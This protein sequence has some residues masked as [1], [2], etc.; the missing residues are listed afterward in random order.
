MKICLLGEFTGD[1]DEGM[2]KTSF[3]LAEELSK[4]HQ[5]ITL[6][7]RDVYSRN[8]WKKIKC[9]RPDIIHY[10]HGPSIKSFVLAKI[11][12]IYSK[13]SKVVMSAMRPVIPY[14]FRGFIPF[15]KPELI[16]AQS[17]E[18]RNMFNSHGCKTKL[19]FC[20][21]DT[22]KFKPV[23][24]DV[25]KELRRKYGFDENQ[26][27]ILHIGSIKEGRNIQ[28]L[29]NI[30]NGENQILIVGSNSTGINSKIHK[31][32][33]ESGC[34]VWSKYIKNVEEIYALSDCYIYPTV[35][36]Y[37]FLKRSIADSIETPLSVLEAMASNLPVI[38]TKFGSLSIIFKEGDGLFFVKENDFITPL[39]RVKND[40]VIIK[41]RNNATQYSWKNM[42]EKL[43]NIYFEL[44]D[45][46]YDN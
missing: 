14:L 19:L 13:D 23:S 26:F 36:R 38:T 42:A 9:F 16:L 31:S 20:G 30:Q 32:L 29:K 8:F 1:L 46:K 17:I 35:D 5:I 25:K 7:L 10:I 2:R 12:S 15:F 6:D 41:T 4:K 45:N 24:K 43:D 3:Y 33:V 27:I 37:D 39:Y 34:I 28:L 44:I 18:T 22:E 21:V 40:N 11:I